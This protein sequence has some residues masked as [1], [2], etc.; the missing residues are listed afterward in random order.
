MRGI[1]KSQLLL[2][3]AASIAAGAETAQRV[4]R[5]W[6]KF[7]AAVQIDTSSDIYAVGD[8]H[9]DYGRLAALLAGAGVITG[10]PASPD[11]PAW[12]AGA[13]VLVFMG[14]LIDKGPNALAVLAL[15]R[16]LQVRAAGAGGRVVVLMGN[17]EAEFLAR[18]NATKSE[19]FAAELSA[20]GLNPREVAECGVEVGRFLCSLPFAARVNDWFFSHAGNTDGRTFARLSSDLT[21]AV[22]HDGFAS[23]QLI[24][25]NS[26]LEARIGEKGP[27]GHSWFDAGGSQMS[28]DRLLAAYASALDV[29][30]IVE[31]HHHGETHFPDGTMRR[32]G[33]MFNWHGKLFLID[34]GMSR[35]IDDST[36]AILHIRYASQQAE[37]VCADG[38]R[39]LLWNAHQK[40]E[41]AKAAFCRAASGH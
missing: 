13:S 8:I 12:S 27:H 38:H 10:L 16:A 5:D 26:L 9:G 31:G 24:G 40:G 20:A 3:L 25:P 29:H 2:L 33:E 37:A 34:T 36:G 7:P 14:D 19:D 28:A 11:R 30:H 17:H 6:Q 41:A 4:G 18:P 35:E 21:A 1:L 22:D 23:A 39:T 15:V 32:A